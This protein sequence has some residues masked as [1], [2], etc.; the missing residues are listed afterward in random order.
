MSSWGVGGIKTGERGREDKQTLPRAKW[1]HCGPQ[2]DG[3][4]DEDPRR[5]DLMT[6][7]RDEPACTHAR[8]H[9]GGIW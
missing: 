7:Q 8:T 5:A 4:T 2:R 1:A 9:T 6:H 3:L